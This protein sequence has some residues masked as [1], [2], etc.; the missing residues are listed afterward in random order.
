MR[1]KLY[2]YCSIDTLEL[3]LK[4]QTIR[5]SSL[6]TV[7]DIEES[8]T[9][10]GNE[11]GK[12]C[13]VSCWTDLKE[14]TVDMWRNYT[15][16]GKGIRIGLPKDFFHEKLSDDEKINR[17]QDI[18]KEYDISVSPPYVPILA[19]VTYTKDDSLIE[20]SVLRERI[21]KCSNCHNEAYVLDLETK[22]VGRF[23]R[24]IW[25]NQS[26]WRYILYAIPYQNIKNHDEGK[27]S[28]GDLKESYSL[29]KSDM[30]NMKFK[31]HFID[32]Q[33]DKNAF[34]NLE[35]LTSPLNTEEENRQVQKLVTEYIPDGQ[36]LIKQS[37]LQI[38]K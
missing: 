11:L 1:G 31:S 38:R 6:S 21:E 8:R 7:D 14:D 32:Y 20:L 4:N 9:M 28:K 34:K 26:E 5:F 17:H 30:I 19:P 2:H 37:K 18:L 10:D 16:I 23:K 27:Y 24:N 22:F 33:F 35:I 15:S 13:F 36:I 3:I 25:S 29:L 12:V